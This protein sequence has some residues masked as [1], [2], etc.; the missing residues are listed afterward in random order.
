MSAPFPFGFP[1]PTALYLSF[2]VL[3]LLIHVLFMSYVLAGTGYLVAVHFLPGGFAAS[4][5]R[6]PLAEI[7]RD[8]MPFALSGAITA[9]VAP[10]LFVQI[11]YPRPFYTANLLLF[12][13]WMAILPVL[14][15][16]FYLL[17]ILKTRWVTEGPPARGGAIALAA[18]LCFGFTG[19]SWTENHLLSLQPA[20][21]P[22]FYGSDSLF[23]W[24][25][26]L[27]PRLAVWTLGTLPVMALLLG[28]QFHLTYGQ[29]REVP[30]YELRRLAA[31]ALAGLLLSALAGTG[32]GSLLSP[33]ARAF[34][35]GGAGGPYLGLALIGW[36]IQA[37]IWFTVWGRAS[38]RP[39]LLG[40]AS[41][42]A[43]LSVLGM[44]VL[45]EGVRLAALPAERFY[46]LH[47][48]AA[49]VGGLPVFLFFLVLNAVLVG[50]SIALARKA[51]ASP[52]T[53]EAL[54]EDIFGRR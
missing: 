9:G 45:R 37:A 35:Q 12:H 52:G 6:S 2:Y 41:L 1:P 51:K 11:L 53:G 32:Y 10:L 38:L 26:H 18:W 20:A 42:G 3:T 29:A 8:W 19:Y 22:A 16:G 13:R 28:W 27:L 25:A 34:V 4:R 49:Q 33:A 39:G 23:F 48:R 14:I 24:S 30:P 54:R 7:L 36:L 46:A 17:Y 21:W 44:T 31:I 40:A 5:H 47:E 50:W 43:L 15:A